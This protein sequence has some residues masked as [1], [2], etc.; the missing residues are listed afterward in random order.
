LKLKELIQVIDKNI[1]LNIN[2]NDQQH[3]KDIPDELLDADIVK[4]DISTVKPHR[5]TLE[6]LG[7]S[8]EVGV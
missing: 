5:K 8:F 2:I 6:K 4:I 7:Y 3:V 1:S